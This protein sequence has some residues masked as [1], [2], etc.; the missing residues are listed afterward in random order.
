MSRASEIV[1]ELWTSMEA[2]DWSRVASLLGPA[3]RAE[4]PQSGE[5]FDRDGY[6]TLN[7]DYP[8]NWHIRIGPVVDG[9]A[10]IV[11]EV[12]VDIDDRTERAVSFFQVHEGLITSLREFWPEPFPA[13]EW[14][15]DLV[16]KGE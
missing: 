4:F 15:R 3:F 9:D 7:R 14:R 2:R 5:R 11:T 16:L 10:T 6:L 8:G 1:V 12:E 13:P